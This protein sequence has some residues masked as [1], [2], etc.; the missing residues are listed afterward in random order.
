MSNEWELKVAYQQ[1]F[2]VGKVLAILFLAKAFS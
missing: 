2:L 1:N